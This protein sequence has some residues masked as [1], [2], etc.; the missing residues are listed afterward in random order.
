ML[1]PKLAGRLSRFPLCC[2]A[3]LLAS[4]V[5][6]AFAEPLS[7]DS[8]LALAVRE[9]PALR[10]EAAQVDAA[11]HAAIPAGA[12]PDPKLLLGID[13][14]P[15]EGPDR[16][17]LTRDFMTMR[18]IG[19]MQEFP[20][21][22]KRDARV[23]A[24]RG[25][26]ALTEAQASITRLTVLRETAVAWIARDA[27]ERQL[28]RI[29]ALD[30]ENRLFDAAV[31]ARLAGGK[32]SALDA[33]APRQEAAMIDSRRDELTARRQQA[34]AALKRWIGPRAEAPLTGSVPDWPIAHVTLEHALYGHPEL[35]IFDPKG[36]MLDAEVAEA[37]AEK[38][39]DWALELAY[40]KRGA[41]FGDMAMVQVSF[42]LPVFAATRQDPKIAARLAERVGLDAERE[43][44]LREHAAMLETDFAEYQRL[45]NAVKRQRG[46]LLPLAG[47]KV[48]LAL[49]SWR[50]GKGE[51]TDL[52]MARRERIDAEL[53][54]I[55]LEGERQQMAARLRYAYSEHA[56][57][58]PNLSGE[59]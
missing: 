53:M 37:R 26:V 32:G 21:A 8:A 3:L 51:L 40:Q 15:I 38:K 29:D 11:R 47:E 2:T 33:V 28:A 17:S 55:A 46:V 22:A 25:R 35:A 4:I 31:R 14:L 10:A 48:D 39:P 27:V 19:L 34:I 42:D 30:S 24:A 6:T 58:E 36:R 9:T 16:Y 20:N 12:L 7:F 41:Q 43:A 59:K 49:A 13:N 18:R 50:G 57:S 44:V 54:A 52:I 23:A 56:Y 1:I 5:G 45:A